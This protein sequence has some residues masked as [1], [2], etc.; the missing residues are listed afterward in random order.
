MYQEFTEACWQAVREDLEHAKKEHFERRG[1]A[2]R[3]VLCHI[4]GERI[5]W[6]EAHLDHQ[7]PVSFQ[8]IVMPFVHA[9]GLAIG[10]AML[11]APADKQFVTTFLD[12]DLET[13][14]S[15]YHDGIAQRRIITKGFNL[16]PGCTE[17]IT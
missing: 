2:E 4:T 1:D 11:S 6:K 3:K 13:R 17:T 9:D 7:K 5:G 16:S 15:S 10:R 8:V 12:K 14:F